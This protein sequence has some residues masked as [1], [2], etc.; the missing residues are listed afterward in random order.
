[1]GMLDGK[2]AL[3]VGLAS[4]RS[5]AWGIAKAMQREGAELAFTFQNDKLRD[6]VEKLAA[7]C[8]TEITVPCDVSEDEEIEAVFDHLDDYWDHLDIIVHSVAYAPRTELE[9]DYLESVSRE[10]FRIAQDEASNPDLQYRMQ[11]N[12]FQGAFFAASPLMQQANLDEAGLFEAIDKQLRH[13]FGNKGERIVQ[14][15]LRVVRRGFDEIHEIVDKTLD[16]AEAAPQLKPL[17]LPV[18]LQQ[19]P[20]ADGALSDVHRFWEQT[21]SFYAAV[22][23]TTPLT[24]LKPMLQEMAEECFDHAERLKESLAI[25]DEPV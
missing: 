19:L 1:M 15:N 8:G 14:D 3:I 23:R 16:Q 10:G 18:M 13:K 22:A 2:R 21:G 7:D 6:R 9:G 11:G 4:N 17:D 20:P 25:P 24:D 5:I 12:A